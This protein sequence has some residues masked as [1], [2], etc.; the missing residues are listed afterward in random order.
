MKTPDCC[1]DLDLPCFGNCPDFEKAFSVCFGLLFSPY[2]HDPECNSRSRRSSVSGEDGIDAEIASIFSV[3][4][5][6][7]D[8]LSWWGL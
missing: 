8:T 2:Q 3:P 6:R 7:D 5:S 4:L 1:F